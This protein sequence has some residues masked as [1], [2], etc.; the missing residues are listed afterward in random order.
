MQPSTAET[1]RVTTWEQMRTIESELFLLSARSGA[2]SVADGQRFKLLCGEHTH[3]ASKLLLM[4]RP[5]PP[6]AAASGR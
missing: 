6:S 1:Q 3:L 5:C 4:E 2:L